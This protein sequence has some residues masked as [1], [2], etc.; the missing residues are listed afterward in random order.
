MFSEENGFAKGQLSAN[1]S[2]KQNYLNVGLHRI[3]SIN[4]IET[5]EINPKYL[6]NYKTKI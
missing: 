3:A 1:W 6:Y 5:I 4:T 2:G